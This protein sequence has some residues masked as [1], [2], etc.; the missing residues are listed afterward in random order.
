MSPVWTKWV[1]AAALS[2]VM[3]ASI[4]AP[5]SAAHPAPELLSVDDLDADGR[6]DVLVMQ[7]SPNWDPNHLMD[8][9][10]R[11]IN[12]GNGATM[13]SAH[14]DYGRFVP[15]HLTG[16]GSVV[17]EVDSR[18]LP[19]GQ[20]FE[21][22][23][24]RLL[25]GGDGS[26]LW[27]VPSAVL[28]SK[29]H[30][31]GWILAQESRNTSSNVVIAAAPMPDA[32][33]DGL[34]DVLI[35][36]HTE[37]DGSLPYDRPLSTRHGITLDG[38]SGSVVGVVTAPP[39][40]R[41]N[42]SVHPD[43]RAA[44]QPRIFPSPDLD[45]DGLGDVISYGESPTGPRLTAWPATGSRPFW[46]VAAAGAGLT[47]SLADL[48]GDG[49]CDVAL[50]GWLPAPPGDIVR[51]GPQTAV[52]YDGR[53]GALLHEWTAPEFSVQRR[54]ALIGDADG[55]SGA[56]VRYLEKDGREWPSTSSVEVIRGD[57]SSIWQR[58]EVD[59]R[60][61]G[62]A[63]HD[64]GGDRVMDA[65]AVRYTWTGIDYLKEFAA[66]S[67]TDGTEL[68]ATSEETAPFR[69]LELP[70]AAWSPARA[71]DA[72]GDGAGDV[73]SGDRTSGTAAKIRSG[74]DLAPVAELPGEQGDIYAGQLDGDSGHEVVV[75]SGSGFAA[76]D[77]PRL[78]W[79]A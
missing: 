68:W 51:Y 8:L 21:I 24:L 42:E 28:K 58:S 18:P 56:D 75:A 59:E 7:S 26:V 54:Y 16:L 35:T 19:D 49:L 77:G 9:N 63:D 4:A 2:C 65:I 6:D 14:L 66:L 20:Q 38:T 25:R 23:R 76:F 47:V 57:G 70:R 13:W 43:Q 44:G 15:F 71:G 40:N 72:N 78:L 22:R 67:G 53:N 45:G 46:T 74:L 3:T 39:D 17:L 29:I 73:I 52:W 1:A 34:D 60:I 37:T 31:D 61:E 64:L 79:R 27:D 55:R 36:T 41:R 32:N 69:R 30:V 11:A 33:G 62:L 10:L 48:S 12:G 5:T 50:D